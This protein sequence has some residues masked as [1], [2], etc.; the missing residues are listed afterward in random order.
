ML[1]CSF[2]TSPVLC[3]F[4]Q[5]LPSLFVLKGLYVW[6]KT[7]DSWMI[8][9]LINYL[10]KVKNLYHLHSIKR[11]K[12]CFLYYALENSFCFFLPT[13]V[14]EMFWKRVIHVLKFVN[15]TNEHFQTFQFCWQF[16]VPFH[17]FCN[18]YVEKNLFLYNTILF[19]PTKKQI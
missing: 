8:E 15:E 19:F 12:E 18:F 5:I 11:A 9:N 13:K 10:W 16:V 6:L 14:I 4:I 17:N 2:I 7:C 1:D 3:H